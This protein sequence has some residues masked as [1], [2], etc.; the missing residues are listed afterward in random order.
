M[1]A[2][3]RVRDA[4]TSHL[5]TVR[6]DSTVGELRALFARYDEEVMA[7]V[8]RDADGGMRRLSGLV[9]R[10]D[11]LQFLLGAKSVKALEK[12]H[13]ETVATIARAVPPLAMS[14]AL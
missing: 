4:M 3:V 2:E 11:L 13:R 1:T 8:S 10:A 6:S 12:R 9:T 7:V 5:V 14:D